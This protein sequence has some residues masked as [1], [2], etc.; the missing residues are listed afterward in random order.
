MKTKVWLTL[1]VVVLFISSIHSSNT[2]EIGLVVN[3]DLYPLIESTLNTYKA[4]LKS[5]Q[6]I[7]IVWID[8]AFGPD[9]FVHADLLAE[10]KKHY[11]SDGIDGVIFIGDLPIVSCGIGEVITTPQ[12]DLYWMDMDDGAFAGGPYFGQY[13]GSGPEIW[14]SRITTSYFESGTGK[15]EDQIVK[16]YFARVSER[17][18]GGLVDEDTSLFVIGN[19]NTSSWASI[20]DE[21]VDE[22]YYTN[23]EVHLASQGENTAAFWKKA[24]DDSHEYMVVYNHSNHEKHFMDDNQQVSI[25]DLYQASGAVRFGNMFACLNSRLD[26]A[27]MVAAYGLLGE[28]L[29]CIGS[30]KSGSIKPGHFHFYNEPLMEPGNLFGD[31]WLSW[32]QNDGTKEMDWCSAM[33][34]EGVGTLQLR[35]FGG[36]TAVTG[37]TSE[38]GDGFTVRYINN[39]IE[40]QVPEGVDGSKVTI[41]V[42]NLQGQLIQ[43]VVNRKALPRVY[44]FSVD[45]ESNESRICNGLYIFKIEA[46][47]LSRTIDV[48]LMK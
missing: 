19:D 35:P 4:E 15:S 24:I 28:G 1:T 16:E 17:M 40:Y 6:N 12:C 21:N 42:Y 48:S 13:Y 45:N 32:W 33:V 31:A 22:L 37:K 3:R 11:E 27:N 38:K 30:G 9:K 41:S 2:K 10:I 29:L 46:A 47:G 8:K 43:S 39:R 23:N 5:I 44:S 20:D 25:Q 34:M 14:M 26:Y 7:D 36:Q 18:N